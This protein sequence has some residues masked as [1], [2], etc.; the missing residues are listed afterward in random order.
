MGLR[1]R[2]TRGRLLEDI[3]SKQPVQELHAELLAQATR[4]GEWEVISHD[5]TFKT[6]FAIIG[7]DKMAQREG[8]L[9]ALHTIVG[10]TGAVPGMSMQATEGRA[11]F[12]RACL[13]ILPDAARASTKWIY[14]DCPDSVEGATDVFPFLQGVAE[15]ALH[16]VLRLEACFGE[17]RTAMSSEV[18]LLQRKFARPMPAPVYHGEAAPCGEEGR[19]SARKEALAK[20]ERD[21]RAYSNTPYNSHQEYVDD[22]LDI[23][24][25]FPTDMSRKDCKGRSAKQ[26]LMSGAAYRHF[27][28][29]RNGNHIASQFSAA[30]T[31]LSAW[32]TTGNEALHFQINNARRTVLQQHHEAIPPMLFS[33]ALQK[34]MAHNSAAY[35]PTLAQRS[36]AE[37]LSLLRGHLSACF[38]SSFG[39]RAIPPLTNRDEARRPARALDQAKT[40]RAKAVAASQRRRWGQHA[41]K[42]ERRRAKRSVPGPPRIK[43]TV[44]TKRKQPRLHRTK[45]Q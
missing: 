25:K 44:F 1:N 36:Q 17:K 9:H 13:A 29:L 19:W 21:L 45:G 26:I 39:D 22:L 18:L 15:D 6:L 5:A 20:P 32:G 40:Q 33:F 34:M 38:F 43:R 28:Y 2:S 11:C 27:A 14:S 16:L 12:K 35:A 24:L 8:E 3:L 37:L 10:K 7:Q 41:A 4:K 31:Q 23:T 30:E 42:L